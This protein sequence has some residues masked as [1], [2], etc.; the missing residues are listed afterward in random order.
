MPAQT[1]PDAHVVDTFVD[2]LSDNWNGEHVNDDRLIIAESDEIGKG[3]DLSTYDY[4][5]VSKTSPFDEDYADLFRSTKDTDAALYVELKAANEARRDAMFDEFRRIVDLHKK[6]PETPGNYDRMEID[7]STPLDDEAFGAYVYEIVVRLEARSRTQI[8]YRVEDD[9]LIIP[10]GYTYVVE[11]GTTETYTAVEDDGELIVNGT[12]NLSIST[13]L[14]EDFEDSSITDFQTDSFSGNPNHQIV[15]R[16]GDNWYALTADSDDVGFLILDAGTEITGVGADMEL[17]EGNIVGNIG[18]SPA[19]QPSTGFVFLLHSRDNGLFKLFQVTDSE[20]QGELI[21]SGFVNDPAEFDEP[22]TSYL[23]IN[24]EEVSVRVETYGG[25]YELTG[26]LP[27]PESAGGR[28]VGLSNSSAQ[29]DAGTI[30]FDDVRE[31][32]VLNVM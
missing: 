28:Y 20:P 30:Y 25:E 15:D 7:E 12:L 26:T 14:L 17:T 22:F 21:E 32:D 3:R 23:K 6:R 1:E 24:N 10:E 4:I 31:V 9:V 8:N 2:L 16:G 27:V 18:I 29:D 13:T 19:Q 11:E 5:E